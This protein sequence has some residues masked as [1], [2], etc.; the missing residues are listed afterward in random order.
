M[1][2]GKVE[3]KVLAARRLISTTQAGLQDRNNTIYQA[4]ALSI[5]TK[6]L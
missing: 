5:F 3:T 1:K 2:E 6:G 4:C